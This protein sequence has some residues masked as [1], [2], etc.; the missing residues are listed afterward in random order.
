MKTT[1][2]ILAHPGKSSFNSQW[3]QASAAA[4]DGEVLWSDLCAMGFDPV[5][6]AEHYCYEKGYESDDFDPL[7]AQSEAAE[8]NQLPSDVAE[9]I[10]KIRAADRI[11]FHFPLWWFGAPAILKGWTDRCL[12]HGAMHNS[13]ERFD[14]GLCKGKEALFCVTTGASAI[15][16]GPDGKEGDTNMH[17]WS[18]AYTLRYCGFTVKQPILFHGIHGY[19]EGENQRRLETRCIETLEAQSSI[20]S[21]WN[22]RTNIAFNSDADFDVEGRLKPNA[23]SYSAFI[24]HADE[25]E[26]KDV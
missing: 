3:A 6:R 13:V 24:K 22:Q 23:K 5:E 7:K 26:L 20:I 19:F 4:C 8:S 18:L 12:T 17:L 21:Q 2:I 15:E 9:E 25:Q 10:T 14:A 16:S 1:L 11:I